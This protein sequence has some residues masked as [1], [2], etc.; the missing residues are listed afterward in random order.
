MEIKL[1]N[2]D[3]VEF[4]KPP[5]VVVYRKTKRSKKYYML[6]TL[7]SIDIVNNARAKKPLVDHKY[8]IIDLGVGQSFIE[9]WTE[10][11][12]VKTVDFVK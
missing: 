7:K 9:K 5:T 6:V 8:E 3:K 2:L 12:K 1:K 10:R 11:Y 4:K